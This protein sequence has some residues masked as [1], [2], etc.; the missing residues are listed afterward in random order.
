MATIRPDDAFDFEVE[1]GKSYD[2]TVEGFPTASD[3]EVAGMQMAQALLLCAVSLDFG[4]RL[5]YTSHEP[6]T[7]FDRTISAGVSNLA[8]GYTSWPQDVVLSE[9]WSAIGT[10]LRD[11]R[12][13][14]SVELFAS[15][16]LE[17]NE[18]AR[19]VMTVSALEPL[20]IQETF[21]SDV[22]ELV[23]SLA[24]NLSANTSI[25][26]GL[27]ASLR[28]RLLQLKKESVRQALKRHCD[29]WFP[30]DADAWRSLDYAYGLRSELLHEG[31]PSDLDILLTEQTRKVANYLRTIYGKEF[32]LSL[33]APLV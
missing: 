20:A 26:A 30:D 24:I 23:D 21:G 11:R 3:A 6:P 15:A 1:G 8:T 13:L 2:L 25:P 33:R 16:A 9:L 14:L 28:G 32:E 10:P 31:R 4:L 12:L 27:K 18:R 29:R 19:F 17:S 22:S 5:S 7:V